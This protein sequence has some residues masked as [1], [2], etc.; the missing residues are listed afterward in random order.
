MSPSLRR[1][2]LVSTLT[3]AAFVGGAVFGQASRAT[4]R[5]ESPYA[6]LEKLGRVLVLVENTYVEPVDRQKALE[7]AI[8]GMVSELDPHSS[9]MSPEDYASFRSDTDGELS[10]IGIEVDLRDE[11]ITV[12]APIEGSPAAKAGI[13]PGDRIVAIDGQPTRGQPIDKLIRKMRGLPGT[14]VVLSLKR[15][16]QERLLT[17]EIVR[18][19]F[20]VASVAGKRL[21]GRVAYLRLKQFQRGTHEELLRLIAKLRDASPEPLEGVL[22]DLRN[23]P[24]GLVE[25]A[26]AVAD[27]FL[28]TGGIYSTKHR[29][30][31]V[32][33]VHA[34]AGG[35]LTKPKVA[36]LVNE[37]SASAAELVA[38][39]LQDAKRATVVGARTFGKGSVQTILD[40][41]GGAGMKLTTM[42]YYTP[43]GRSI[44]ALGIAPDLVVEVERGADQA[45]VVREKDLEG[46]LVPEEAPLR[47]SE[48]TTVHA[49]E[50]TPRRL[51]AP[52]AEMPEDPTTGDDMALS[53]AYR[54]LRRA[55]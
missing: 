38:G 2:G 4:S 8:K 35:A 50:S 13:Q 33:E 45:P 37:N 28:S 7:G 22:L 9:Y 52:I 36:V 54:L 51:L 44:Q 1:L 23:N 19:K 21:A 39:A 20:H 17:V 16:G 27:E 41:P 43:S 48:G 6:I 14:Q 11:N 34:R 46:H 26:V 5:D 32:S 31:V 55:R 15:E 25:E 10:G 30:Q 24:G 29:G 18:E 53:V 3:L 42:R 49:R 47:P 40:L 12:I